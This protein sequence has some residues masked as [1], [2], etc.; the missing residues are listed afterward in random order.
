MTVI[1]EGN[2][3]AATRKMMPSPDSYRPNHSPADADRLLESVTPASP[4]RA[5]WILPTSSLTVEPLSINN[6]APKHTSPEAYKPPAVILVQHV[7]TSRTT[8]SLGHVNL[9]PLPCPS[10]AS[11]PHQRAV[12]AAITNVDIINITRDMNS[13]ETSRTSEPAPSRWAGVNSDRVEC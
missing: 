9:L 13:S 11:Q 3:G 6:N 5:L 10:R 7:A 12:I 1:A 2:C 4:S 8:N